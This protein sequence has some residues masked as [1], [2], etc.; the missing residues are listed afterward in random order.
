[1][2]AAVSVWLDLSKGFFLLGKKL[3]TECRAKLDK[4]DKQMQTT[5]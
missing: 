2:R 4:S 3:V 5:F 1:M